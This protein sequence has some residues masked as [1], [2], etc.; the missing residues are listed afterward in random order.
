M[1]NHGV[2]RVELSAHNCLNKCCRRLQASLTPLSI[3]SL[4]VFFAFQ[5][6]S[7]S[8]QNH[9][10]PL[11]EVVA[12]SRSDGNR[13]ATSWRESL[14]A[15][16]YRSLSLEHGGNY[17]TLKPNKIHLKSFSWKLLP[18]HRCMWSPTPRCIMS[19]SLFSDSRQSLFFNVS[20]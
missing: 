12:K 4:T 7:L 8:S 18:T 5:F 2:D 11:W 10:S 14:S 13:A 6:I 15:T 17:D 16:I 19:L 3:L 1:L 9:S 20:R